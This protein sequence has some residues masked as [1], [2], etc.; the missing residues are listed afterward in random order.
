ML[1]KL[2]YARHGVIELCCWSDAL[3]TPHTFS[4]ESMV[5][6]PPHL[7]LLGNVSSNVLE[8]YIRA[9]AFL[10]LCFVL[11][12]ALFLRIEAG[13]TLFS[14]TCLL[15]DSHSFISNSTL[16][17]LWTTKSNYLLKD[18][19]THTHSFS[20]ALAVSGNLRRFQK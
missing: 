17:C 6:M 12:Q 5:K 1:L 9:L 13:I 18:H 14:C 2:D 4:G 7:P 20:P 3:I 19:K 8:I 11:T 15:Q 16:L 10:L